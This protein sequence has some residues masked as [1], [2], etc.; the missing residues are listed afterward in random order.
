MFTPDVFK[1]AERRQPYN[2]LMAQNPQVIS[3]WREGEANITVWYT[4]SAW[5]TDDWYY[6]DQRVATE[7]RLKSDWNKI[8]TFEFNDGYVL[9]VYHSIFDTYYSD[10]MHSFTPSMLKYIIKEHGAITSKTIRKGWRRNSAT[11][12]KLTLRD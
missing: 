10:R 2:E 5:Q 9:N 4:G 8:A 1:F 12:R 7:V 3:K 11:Y 6:P